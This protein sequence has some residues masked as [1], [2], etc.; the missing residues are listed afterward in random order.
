MSRPHRSPRYVRDVSGVLLLDKAVGLTSNEALQQVKR[1]FRA[2]KA[3]HTGSLD[4]L[5]TG[6]LPICFG[7]ATKVSS[8]LLSADKFYWTRAILGIRTDTGDGD[9]VVLEQ[10]AVPAL[11]VAMIESV[12]GRFRGVIEQVPPMHSAVKHQGRRLY[13]LARQ[14]IT[15]ERQAREVMI[16]RLS[17]VERGDTTVEFDIHCS[18]GTYVRTLVEDIGDALGC[19]AHVA[20]LRRYGVGPYQEPD[21]ITF[22]GLQTL[23]QQGDDALDGVVRPVDSA[24]IHWP[25]VDLDTDSA[26]YVRDGQA[27]QVSGAPAE[28]LVRVYGPTGFLGIGEILDDGRVGPRRLL[29]G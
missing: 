23:A 13:E 14:G 15:V 17:V 26:Y 7:E 27:V 3:G 2:K 24:L 20:A 1:L 12:L 5:A 18:K 28:G 22:E 29:Q 19:G 4:P 10:R 6:L 21:M 8:Y 9:G 25:R 11:T 16:H